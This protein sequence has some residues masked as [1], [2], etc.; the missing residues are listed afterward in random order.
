MKSFN[1]V[2]LY[3]RQLS[4]CGI[5]KFRGKGCLCLILSLIIGRESVRL[6]IMSRQLVN[7]KLM[8]KYITNFVTL[9]SHVALDSNKWWLSASILQLHRT[10]LFTKTYG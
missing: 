3:L 5:F 7:A 9:L 2:S 4:K 8:V 10:L 6:G 1:L